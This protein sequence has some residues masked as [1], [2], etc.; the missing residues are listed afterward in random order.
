MRGTA[1]ESGKTIIVN[2]VLTYHN[3]ISCDS[4]TKSEIVIPI[5]NNNSYRSFIDS[6]KEKDFKN[7]D[8]IYLEKICRLISSENYV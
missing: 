3:Y 4:D 8:R 2:N 6:I 5:F 7:I 1:A